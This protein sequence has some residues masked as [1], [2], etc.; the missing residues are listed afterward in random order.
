[1]CSKKNGVAGLFKTDLKRKMIF[2]H[3]IAHKINLFTTDIIERF[4]YEKSFQSTIY[5]L[6]KFFMSTPRKKSAFWM[7][8]SKSL[9]GIHLV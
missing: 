7:I 4:K 9:M 3:R 6:V 8:T 1:M 5:D 2:F